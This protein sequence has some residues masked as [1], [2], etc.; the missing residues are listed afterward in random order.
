MTVLQIKGALGEQIFEAAELAAEAYMEAATLDHQGYCQNDI[1]RFLLKD[2]EAE[3]DR[4]AIEA[5]FECF[6]RNLPGDVQDAP[7]QEL[8]TT[9]IEFLKKRLLKE[10]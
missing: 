7:D 3:V 6:K 10:G 9:L 1:D 5:T 4:P 2:L 8:R